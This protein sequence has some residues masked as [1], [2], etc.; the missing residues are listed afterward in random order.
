MLDDTAAILISSNDT[1]NTPIPV[2]ESP[3]KKYGFITESQM[4]I[5]ISYSGR[6]R[7]RVFKITQFLKKQ[8]KPNHGDYSVFFDQD[9]QHEIC[10]LNGQHHLH[11]IYQNAKM[12]VVFLS[13]TYTDS[14]YCT[15]EWRTIIDRFVTTPDNSEEKQLLL[16]KLG[17]YD[18]KKLDL[19]ATDFS[20]NGM[21]KSN[22]QI[23]ETIFKRWEA[24]QKND[25]IS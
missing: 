3:V 17:D 12:V 9:F 14:R 2:D 13:P 5:A 7:K 21:R 16:I 19:K 1:S 11:K 15:G 10:R 23:A 18:H 6:E 24:I 4:S 8:M 25:H 22:E 20:L